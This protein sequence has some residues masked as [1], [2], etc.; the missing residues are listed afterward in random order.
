MSKQQNLAQKGMHRLVL[1]ISEQ[2]FCM[3]IMRHS[4]TKSNVSFEKRND[5]AN[6]ENLYKL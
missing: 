3:K 5:Q 6:I 2:I 4:M 1:S